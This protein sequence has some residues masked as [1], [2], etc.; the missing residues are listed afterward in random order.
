MQEGYIPAL[1]WQERY[2]LDRRIGGSGSGVLQLFVST[3]KWLETLTPRALA[4]AFLRPCGLSKTTSLLWVVEK[5]LKSTFHLSKER[6]REQANHVELE[7]LPHNHK[8]AFSDIIKMQWALK[9][10]SM[11]WLCSRG[12]CTLKNEANLFSLLRL[13]LLFEVSLDLTIYQPLHY[14]A[15]AWRWLHLLNL[16]LLNLL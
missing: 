4:Q 8:C 14:A 1:V 5:Y 3:V 9:H 6:K 16:N 7:R 15:T 10:A 13:V 2:C 12:K 11:G